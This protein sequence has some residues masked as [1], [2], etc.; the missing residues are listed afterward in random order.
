MSGTGKHFRLFGWWFFVNSH[1]DFTR[2]TSYNFNPNHG[3]SVR[4]LIV[5]GY[6]ISWGRA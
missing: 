1:T 2:R 3:R 5:L 6:E 4:S